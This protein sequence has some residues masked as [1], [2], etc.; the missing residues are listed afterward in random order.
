[1]R[2]GNATS[3]SPKIK[4]EGTQPIIIVN[5]LEHMVVVSGL[6]HNIDRLCTRNHWVLI[7]CQ[8]LRIQSIAVLC[9]R[10]LLSCYWQSGEVVLFPLSQIGLLELLC[11]L[12]FSFLSPRKETSIE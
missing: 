9:I 3:D 8:W 1:M 7:C 2:C 12:F 11:L 4:L 6:A 5:P 10:V